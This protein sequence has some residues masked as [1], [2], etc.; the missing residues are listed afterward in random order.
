MQRLLRHCLPPLVKRLIVKIR[1]ALKLCALRAR[2]DVRVGRGTSI[3]LFTKVEPHVVVGR[4]CDIS[5]SF[6]GCGTYLVEGCSLRN[7]RIGRFCSIADN[8]RCGLGTH[9]SHTFVSSHPAFFSTNGQAGF[10]FAAENRFDELPRVPGSGYVV[11]IGNDVWIGSGVRILD[12]VR[13]G[14]GAIIGA[15]A[16]VTH[17]VE[18]YSINVGI[19]SRKVRMR[20]TPEQVD[21]LLGFQWWNRDFDW[22]GEN[23]DS[24]ANI[25][26]FIRLASGKRVQS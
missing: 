11:E 5:S 10:T 25:E 24:F 22:I 3:D 14:D 21:F 4:N 9:P 6:V 20:F 8:V 26:E 16:V 2:R 17:D 19:P 12:G 23:V 13:I 15:G 7:V 18:P 1:L